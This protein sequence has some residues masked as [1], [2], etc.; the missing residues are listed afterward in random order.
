[1]ALRFPTILPR[2]MP[3][4]VRVNCDGA[5]VVCSIKKLCVYQALLPVR[6]QQTAASPTTG[7]QPRYKKF[8]IYRWV[9]CNT[10]TGH[11]IP[12]SSLGSGYARLTK[13]GL[14]EGLS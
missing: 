13:E 11:Q 9:S 4:Q 14:K 5:P 1:M 10:E 6:L 2:L 7:E 12:K 3:A 8:L